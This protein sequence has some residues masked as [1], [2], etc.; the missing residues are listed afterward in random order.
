L[1]LQFGNATTVHKY[2]HFRLIDYVKISLSNI[3][4][5][6]LLSLHSLDFKAPF[7]EQTSE[8]GT[9]QIA[10]YHHCKITLYD[11]GVLLF[12]GSI[13]KLFNSLHNTKAPNYKNGRKTVDK[14]YN[15]NQF[16]LTNIIEI[17]THLSELFECEPQQMQFQNIEFGINTNPNTDPQ[18]FI[19]GLLYQRGKKFEFRYNDYYAQVVHQRYILKIYN[20]SHQYGMDKHTLRIETKELKAIDFAI[21]GIKTFA[22]INAH[23]LKNAKQLLL[24]RFDEVMYYDYTINKKR[25]TKRQKQSINNYSNPRYWFENITVKKRYE[26]KKKLRKY[27]SENS[28]N[29]HQKIRAEIM[30]KGGI[31]NRLSETPK[32]GII[33]SSSIELNTPFKPLEIPPTK[34]VRISEKNTSL[35]NMKKRPRKCIVTGVDLD[36]E[37]EDAKYIRKTTL[38]YLKKHHQQKYTEI[39]SSL[40]KRSNPYHTKYESDIITHLAKQIRNKVYNGN[41]IKNIGYNSKM[42]HNQISLFSNLTTKT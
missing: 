30:Q 20:K 13:H 40:L 11:S 14:G 5:T 29:L 4:T 9:K 26:H 8:I 42:Y 24:K 22:D 17:R 36:R 41:T 31:I 32:R 6:R 16:T 37:K 35:K 38:R 15:G 3:D 10:E 39:C 19:K 2:K 23:T 25:L 7:S 21:T 27:I 34:T 1:V 12:T 18:E 28:Q 33:N